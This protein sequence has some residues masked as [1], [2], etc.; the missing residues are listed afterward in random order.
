MKA[1]HFVLNPIL[2][3]WNVLQCLVLDIR[4]TE[5]KKKK[6]SQLMTSSIFWLYECDFS[7]CV[8]I[9]FIYWVS[10]CYSFSFLFCEIFWIWHG[11][12]WQLFRLC[13]KVN[14]TNTLMHVAIC[15][16]IWKLICYFIKGVWRCQGAA[17]NSDWNYPKDKQLWLH[18]HQGNLELHLTPP[19]L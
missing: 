19:T 14:L 10:I 13:N 11:K 7:L 12:A 17:V 9:L 2:Y 4:P 6:R 1:L 18:F 8:C 15:S 3:L 16:S 5:K